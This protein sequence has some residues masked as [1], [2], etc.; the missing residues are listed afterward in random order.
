[1]SLY[2][3]I[4]AGRSVY[5]VR[6][7]AGPPESRVRVNKSTGTRDRA[8]AEAYAASLEQRIWDAAVFG[9]KAVVTYAEA[10]ASYL[11]F[12]RPGPRD[13]NGV[14]RLVE[15]FGSKRLAEVTADGGQAQLDGALAALSPPDRP[16]HRGIRTPHIA[17]LTH[18]AKRGWCPKP[19]F[20]APPAGEKRTDWLLPADAVRLV[21]CAAPH[22][23]P[24]LWFLMGTGAR[25]GEA[26]SL[27]WDDVDLAAGVAV[28]WEDRTKAGKK[29]VAELSPTAIVAMANLKHRSG[30][31]FRKR[32]TRAQER[33]G[34]PGDPY[35]PKDDEG[36][37]FKTGWRAACRRAGLIAW[38]RNETTGAAET[39]ELADGECSPVRWVPTILPH[40]LRHSWATWFQAAT[41]DP[42][43]L[44][45]A[46]GWSTVTLV[47]RYA[48][49]MKQDDVPAIALA[50]GVAHPDLF[51][52]ALRERQQPPPA[53]E[54]AAR[55]P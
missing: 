1:M 46:G 45:T 41:K 25:V 44:R 15:Y 12:R 2:V 39:H 38:E 30:L 35:A 7:A 27:T 50:W 55:K 17:V 40:G 52:A 11:E 8:R 5:Y 47:E 36:G 13:A 21:N 54:L 23:R 53:P 4:P 10:A 14:G 3:E 16:D 22:L 28:F 48:H 51:Q 9:Q 6:G 34:M 31:V 49:R 20:E 24:L 42:M 37:Q 33:A 29:R 32:A 26:L 43:R 19:A 18:A